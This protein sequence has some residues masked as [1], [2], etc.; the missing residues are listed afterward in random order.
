MNPLFRYLAFVFLL[1]TVGV[2]V[3]GDESVVKRNVVFILVDD[4]DQS[5]VAEGWTHG[6]NAAKRDGLAV[7]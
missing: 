4:Q 2:P 7:I 5:P 6:K 1:S 3:R